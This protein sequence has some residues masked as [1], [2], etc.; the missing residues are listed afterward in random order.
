MLFIFDL[1]SHATIVIHP[2]HYS[3]FCLFSLGGIFDE[4]RYN[5]AK[6]KLIFPESS[7]STTDN[8]E[9]NTQLRK[10]WSEMP[11]YDEDNND[12]QKTDDEISNIRSDIM[13][14]KQKIQSHL[15]THISDGEL[16]S[17]KCMEMLLNHHKCLIFPSV[18]KH[19][20]KCD[21]K[22]QLSKPPGLKNLGATCYLNSQLQCLAQNLG[23]MHAIMR[24][25]PTTPALTDTMSMA[26][27]KRMNNVLSSMQ[28]ILARMRYGHEN[29]ICTN[30]FALALGL[31]NDEMQDPNEV[32]GGC[33][34]CTS[35]VYA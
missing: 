31:E 34:D 14:E 2:M 35:A 19:L 10:C 23:F 11:K 9:F 21:S 18:Q 29:V 5:I 32:R 15:A 24:W 6:T 13:I 28:S 7:S 26:S 27:T 20:T 12:E 17:E 25:K 8:E 3:K 4:Y 1:S 16:T 33:C 30:E 22:V